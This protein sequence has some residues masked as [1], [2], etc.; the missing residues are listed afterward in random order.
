[1]EMDVHAR[2]FFSLLLVLLPPIFPMSWAHTPCKI[3]LTLF[4]IKYSRLRIR[5]SL[6]RSYTSYNNKPSYR[7][8][9]GNDYRLYFLTG[10]G[11]LIGDNR[12]SPRGYIHNSD[13]AQQCPYSILG[14]WMFFSADHHAWYPDN[15]L[16]LRCITP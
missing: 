7:Q 5:Y 1:M 12:G 13:K 2:K 9:Y 4:T 3:S 16:V 6:P 8:N 15:T 11:W 14:G 10:S